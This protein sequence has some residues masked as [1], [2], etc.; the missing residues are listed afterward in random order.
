MDDEEY[1]Q[2][3]ADLLADRDAYY[4]NMNTIAG[5]LPKQSYPMAP[6]KVVS[7]PSVQNTASFCHATQKDH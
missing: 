1:E 3:L 5:P 6:S 2:G 4:A 7:R